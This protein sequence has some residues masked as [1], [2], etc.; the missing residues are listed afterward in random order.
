LASI[1]ELRKQID[2]ID[3]EIMDLL[4]KR[5]TLST[6]IGSVK[7]AT[8]APVLDLNREELI[9]NKTA[10]Y[11]HSQQIRRIYQTIMKESKDLQRK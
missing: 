8:N 11:S 7:S 9:L 2:Q 5:Y 1:E 4:D 10:N 3:A 6:M